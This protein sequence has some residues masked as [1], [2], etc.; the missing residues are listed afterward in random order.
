MA[1]PGD[2]AVRLIQGFEPR[3]QCE[4]RSTRNGAQ[5]HDGIDPRFGDGDRSVHQTLSCEETADLCQ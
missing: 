5:S 3:E 1:G 4:S 2:S